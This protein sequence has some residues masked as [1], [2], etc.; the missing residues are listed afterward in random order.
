MR[1][2]TTLV[3]ALLLFAAACGG[4]QAA[5]PEPTATDDRPHLDGALVWDL[6]LAEG[7]D[8]VRFVWGTAE[9]LLAERGPESPVDLSLDDYAEWMHANWSPWLE[10]RV[11]ALQELRPLLAALGEAGERERVFASVV[12]GYLYGDFA[13]L[14]EAMPVPVEVQGEA[15]LRAAFAEQLRSQAAPA[16]GRAREAFRQCVEWAPTAPPAL[17]GWGEACAHRL[18]QIPDITAA[19]PRPPAIAW[20]DE[21]TTR[22]TGDRPGAPAAAPIGRRPIALVSGSRGPLTVGEMDRVVDAVH[23]RLRRVHRA[24]R[25]LPLRE[26]RAARA[27]AEQRRISP[28][29]VCTRAPSTAAVLRRRHHDLVTASVMADCH[30]G[31]GRED[32]GSTCSLTVSFAGASDALDFIVAGVIAEDSFDVADW[33]AAVP[34]LGEESDTAHVFGALVGSLTRGAGG[35]AARLRSVHALGAWG[36]ASPTHALRG[37]E[38][39][40]GACRDV[41]DVPASDLTVVLEVAPDGGVSDLDVALREGATERV[42][43]V[44]AVFEDLELPPGEGTR[45]LTMTVEFGPDRSPS[46]PFRAVEAQPHDAAIS[47]PEALADPFLRDAVARCYAGNADAHGAVTSHRARLTVDAA[48]AVTGVVVEGVTTPLGA[49]EDLV[50]CI[51]GALRTARFA[52]TPGTSEVEVEAVFCVGGR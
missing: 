13:R 39:R 20:P 8:D 29:R 41:G 16:W 6:S 33:L 27:N 1:A 45:R 26:V 9:R 11:V 12:A 19:P 48:G 3:A 52:C 2:P 43:C 34:Q 44:T 49:D 42:A 25:F 10:A 30:P 37:A 28:R 35:G 22:P 23:A 5:Q 21:C 15:E 38:P 47:A 46:L 31:D 24:F 4:P 40:L 50:A 18:E 36:D 7:S 17:A 14:I 32:E 51:T